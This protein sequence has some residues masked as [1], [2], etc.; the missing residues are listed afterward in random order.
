MADELVWYFQAIHSSILS[1]INHDMVFLQ[2][3]VRG[4]RG[5]VWV[6][7][8]Q[9]NNG[10][11]NVASSGSDNQEAVNAVL[12]TDLFKTP[13]IQSF[14]NVFLKIDTEGDECEA[15]LASPEGYHQ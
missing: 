10:E 1:G 15:I 4:S 7:E 2:N 12:L 5:T 13:A 9:W 11:A 6:N 14:P 3:A 8:K